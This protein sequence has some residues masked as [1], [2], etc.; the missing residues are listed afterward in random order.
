MTPLYDLRLS[1]AVYVVTSSGLVQGRGHVEVARA[2]LEGGATAIQLRAPELEDRP[3]ELRGVGAEIAALSRARGVLFIVNDKADVALEVG[4]DGVHMGQSDE[5][6]GGRG[7]L[8]PDR[9][10]GVSV[11]TIDQAREAE[12][13]GAD[14][15]GVTVFETE[16]KPEATSVG[17]EGLRQIAASTS[18]PVV[19]IG[20]IDASN[21][22]EVLA[23]GA[24]GV[25]VVSAVGA[26]PDPVEATRELVRVVSGYLREHNSAST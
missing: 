2:A 23:A 6:R 26:A 16:T 17:L 19:G 25:A 1:L 11:E 18:L 14:Y 10:L 8:P 24:V 5:L 15:L 12:R 7:R 9:L 4:A 21:A 13:F 3:D 20:G 22:R